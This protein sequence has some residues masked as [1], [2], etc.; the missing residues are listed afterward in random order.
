[1]LKHIT[2]SQDEVSL[3]TEA[4]SEHMLP[5]LYDMPNSSSEEDA[6]IVKAFLMRLAN[7]EWTLSA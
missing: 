3:I 6:K 2:L 7:T 4:L 5:M 1:M